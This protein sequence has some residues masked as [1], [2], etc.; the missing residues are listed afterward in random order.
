MD[1]L[2]NCGTN[3][4][5]EIS[6]IFNIDLLSGLY[7]YVDNIAE[8]TFI[9]L[10]NDKCKIPHGEYYR[11]FV[12]RHAIPSFKWLKRED[13]SYNLIFRGISEMSNINYLV[14]EYFKE[15]KS[16][17]LIN[18]ENNK[19]L[20]HLE[21]NYND[22]INNL[23]E[24]ENPIEGYINLIQT[25]IK[26]SFPNLQV[27]VIKSSEFHN[28]L[29]YYRL[30][31]RSFKKLIKQYSKNKLYNFINGGKFELL[32]DNQSVA[33]IV[34]FSR[35]NYFTQLYDSKGQRYIVPKKLKHLSKEKYDFRF[36]GQLQINS[37]QTIGKIADS[38]YYISYSTDRGKEKEFISPISSRDI[39]RVSKSM[40]GIGNRLKPT[41]YSLFEFQD[42]MTSC[43]LKS[44]FENSNLKLADKKDWL[45][46]ID[47]Y[48]R[49]GE[50]SSVF[51]GSIKLYIS[52]MEKLSRLKYRKGKI[53]QIFSD[54][55]SKDNFLYIGLIIIE[56]WSLTNFVCELYHPKNNI[57][58]T[59][60]ISNILIKRDS[61]YFLSFIA[62]RDVII[63]FIESLT[64]PNYPNKFPVK[65]IVRELANIKRILL[66]MEM[67]LEPILKNKTSYCRISKI[68][69][70]NK[71]FK[72]AANHYYS[73]AVFQVS[74]PLKANLLLMYLLYGNSS[75][76]RINEIL[77]Q[78]KDK[79]FIQ[80]NIQYAK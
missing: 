53:K 35:H 67:K 52:R 1:L 72:L 13:Q 73:Y 46:L 25:L 4:V 77:K 37:L 19:E 30:R 58:P 17:L 54:P 43:F 26:L 48:P 12:S 10:I 74:G 75:M 51:Q 27:K 2:K 55:K 29:D 64:E 3:I 22:L 40:F 11:G 61:D 78:R 47:N 65:D 44:Y 28:S 6:S 76:K 24:S 20:S 34:A 7:H 66:S 23:N 8:T 79:R 36:I 45:S 42:N 59:Q 15:I 14:T 9:I 63:S 16:I 68:A 18:K 39:S 60:K 32:K 38:P 5:L 57:K 56:F 33:T 80:Y 71:H 62:Y 31:L 49:S 70:L 50:K 69:V 21:N 41:G